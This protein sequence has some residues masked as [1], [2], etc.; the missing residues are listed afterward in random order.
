MSNLEIYNDQPAAI[1][2]TAT[3]EMAI[4]RQSQEVQAAMIIAK[5]FPRDEINAISRIKQSCKRITL[6]ENAVYSYPRGGTK[7]EGPSIRLAEV[8]AQTWGNIDFGIIELEQSGGES[9]V[10][11]YAWDLE[12]NTRQ[13]KIFQ[14]PHK[15]YTKNGT[16]ALT[17]PRDIYE[18]VA[19]N[20]A[21]RL[22]ACILG[23]IP[24]DI[25][26][27]ALSQCELTIKGNNTEPIRDRILKMVDKFA[28]YSVNKEMLESRIGCNIEAFDENHIIQLGKIYTSL[29]DGMSKPGDYFQATKSK[30]DSIE[31]K[32]N[33]ATNSIQGPPEMD[34]RKEMK[35]S[36][37]NPNGKKAELFPDDAGDKF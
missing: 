19:N 16:Y 36:T 9:S 13:T 2:K 28:A 15:R 37:N 33:N 31:K 26:D 6:A 8:L 4:S 25:V 29:K 27:M 35:A 3:V 23:V 12:S 7:V 14:V 5:R 34:L 18:T 10:M 24:G 20:G 17:D 21:R 30:K 32:E 11:A 1:Q 22:R